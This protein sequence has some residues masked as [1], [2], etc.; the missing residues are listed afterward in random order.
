MKEDHEY[1]MLSA[2]INIEKQL[3]EMDKKITVY[4]EAKLSH[5]MCETKE[6]KREEILYAL[7]RFKR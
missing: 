1:R 7:D 3:K 4:M 5:E 6:E 2:L